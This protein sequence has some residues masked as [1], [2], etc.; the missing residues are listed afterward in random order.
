MNIWTVTFWI[1]VSTFVLLTM[2]LI[3]R[4]YCKNKYYHS[5]YDDEL[6]KEEKNGN[7]KNYIYSPANETKEYILRYILRKSIYDKSIVLNYKEEYEYIEYYIKCFNKH[8]KVIQ[9]VDVKETN[10]TTV[11]KIICLN[12]NTDRVNVFVKNVNHNVDINTSEIRPIPKKNIH[13]YSI[14]VSL[15][16][17]ALIYALRH[18]IL[19]LVLKSQ[20]RPFLTNG[21][22]YLTL[23]IILVSSVIMYILTFFSIR[24]RNFRNKNRGALRYE[25]Y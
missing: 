8:K 3:I 1:T 20:F 7:A 23:L 2:F 13:L 25:F 16:F 10:T 17:F 6:F 5:F 18:L 11:S 12:R 9:V 21:W 24:R 22:N 4:R 15:N 14:A 19:Y